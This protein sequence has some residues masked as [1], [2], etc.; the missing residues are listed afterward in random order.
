MLLK[1]S[2]FKSAVDEALANARENRPAVAM[3]SK[4]S[5]S[6]SPSRAWWSGHRQPRK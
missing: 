6:W 4:Q 3:S 1:T 5:L 2:S